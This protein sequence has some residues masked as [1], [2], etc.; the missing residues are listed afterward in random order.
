ME[1]D[2]GGG[3]RLLRRHLEV[4]KRRGHVDYLWLAIG[5]RGRGDWRGAGCRRAGGG[6]G[7]DGGR[8]GEEEVDRNEE[9]GGKEEPEY[10]PNGDCLSKR[11]RVFGRDVAEWMV[12]SE[13]CS[14]WRRGGGRNVRSLASLGPLA[15]HY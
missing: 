12:M 2:D 5:G 8:G 7:E 14:R 11:G 4:F 6:S 1:E 10:R 13:L 9:E 3:M 15:V